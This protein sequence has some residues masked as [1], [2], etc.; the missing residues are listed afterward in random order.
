MQIPESQPSPAQS[1]SPKQLTNTQVTS[2]PHPSS[3]RELHLLKPETP[4][5]DR[6]GVK[7]N[8]VHRA[9]PSPSLPCTPVSFWELSVRMATPSRQATFPSGVG[10]Y[11]GRRV[12]YQTIFI[13]RY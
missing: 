2:Y 4:A 12:H 6:H 9:R 10:K 3:W 1:D 8:N 7:Q 5:G 13:L 11:Q